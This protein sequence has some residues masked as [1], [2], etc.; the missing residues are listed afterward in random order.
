MDIVKAEAEF[1][2]WP[3]LAVGRR[4]RVASG[5]MRGIE[6][7]VHRRKNM[8]RLVLTVHTLGQAVALEIDGGLLEPVY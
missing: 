3:Y 1:D 8:T 7:I 6:G 4:C 5:P 2:P